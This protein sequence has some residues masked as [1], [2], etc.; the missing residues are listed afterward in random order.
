MAASNEVIRGVSYTLQ[1]RVQ[2]L[3]TDHHFVC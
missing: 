1:Q 2:H 3:V